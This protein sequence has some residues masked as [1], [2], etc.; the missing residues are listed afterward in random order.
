MANGYTHAALESIPGNETNTPTLSTKVIYE[1]V[2]EL[3]LVPGADH[4]M[5]DDEIRNVD[6]PLAVLP[7]KFDP[8][9]SLESRAYPDMT[10]FELSAMLGLPVSTAGDG[11]ITDPDAAII[12][13]TATRHVWTA[14]YGTGLL[15]KT[16]QRQCAYSDQSFYLKAKGCGTDALSIDSPDS[17]GVTLKAGGPAL[18]LA[19]VA[20]PALTAAYEALTIAPFM[21][22][23][24]QIVSWLT[25]TAESEDFTVAVANPMERVRTLGIASKW[26]DQLE[27]GDGP[28]VFTGSIPKRVIDI[29]DYDALIAATGFAVKVRWQSTVNIA[30]TGYKYTLWLECL[31]AQYIEGGPEALANKRRLGGSFNWK[32]TYN[33]TPGSTKITLVNATASYA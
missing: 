22:S 10:G 19:R 24:L 33:G 14:P 32:A 29:D 12:P 28:I 30:A 2:R 13:A 4:M 6:E 31:N 26:A 1:P 15:P 17:G 20:N 23:H 5:R 27:K 7:E 9:W 21:R 3:E 16:A 18:Y 25:G 8:T 11:I